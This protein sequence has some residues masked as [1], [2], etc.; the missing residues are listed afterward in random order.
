MAYIA[1]AASVFAYFFSRARTTF[2]WS[3]YVATA[4]FLIIS[5]SLDAWAQTFADSA[6]YRLLY[7]AFFSLM[8]L[9][10]LVIHVLQMALSRKGET[11]IVISE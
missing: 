3:Y 6:N 10:L 7:A 5:I 9:A 1:L 4:A 11:A 8:L 2:V